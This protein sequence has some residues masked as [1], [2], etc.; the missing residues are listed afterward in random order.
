MQSQHMRAEGCAPGPESGCTPRV[1]G[2]KGARLAQ[3]MDAPPE[4]A[5]GGGRSPGPESGCSEDAA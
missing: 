3:N 4:C 1:C 2:G 5:G